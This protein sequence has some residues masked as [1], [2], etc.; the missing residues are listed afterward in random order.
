MSKGRLKI[1]SF[2]LGLLFALALG[3]TSRPSSTALARTARPSV[4]SQYTRSLHTM[5]LPD[6]TV[7]SP[8]QAS[9]AEQKE[10]QRSLD[11]LEH[12]SPEKRRAVFVQ[13]VREGSIS[14][15]RDIDSKAIGVLPE[16][17]ST[18]LPLLERE[19]F[20]SLLSRFR[21]IDWMN[22]PMSSFA[23]DGGPTDAR[24]YVDRISAVNSELGRFLETAARLVHSVYVSTRK[25]QSFSE[26]D[27]LHELL[28]GADRQPVDANIR[29]A[30]ARTM[31]D[32]QILQNP[33]FQRRFE[34]L[35]SQ[36]VLSYLQS[37]PDEVLRSF[38]LLLSAHFNE[39]DMLSSAL[40]MLLRRFTLD[41]SAKFRE[42]IFDIIHQSLN[43]QIAAKSDAQLQRALAELYLVGAMDA[44][45]AD[46]RQRAAIYLDESQGYNSDLKGQEILTEYLKSDAHLRQPE[47]QETKGD[48]TEKAT[49]EKEPAEEHTSLL[50]RFS[51][52][53][54]HQDAQSKI[55]STLVSGISYISMLLFALLIGGGIFLA[56]IYRR[57]VQTLS[58]LQK[59]SAPH[60]SG[61]GRSNGVRMTA[62]TEMDFG[63]E[64]EL[65]SKARQSPY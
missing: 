44:L 60:H 17:R 28:A 11:Q 2:A 64:F 43:I 1:L 33:I 38:Q 29:T 57:S 52:D 18:I 21:Q 45:E 16:Y 41:A 14:A 35:R 34:Q 50:S 39:N 6:A 22:W 58:G 26:Q 42:Q 36:F 55:R 53:S 9:N 59:S 13:S 40:L 15:L 12:L 27:K 19:G 8:P 25:G 49:Q 5:T 62:P 4:N 51:H 56:I 23:V 3:F 32:A 46:D 37:H 20:D 54:E 65:G 31:L 30:L 10:S 7:V 61:E 24:Q 47:K 63:E 48:E